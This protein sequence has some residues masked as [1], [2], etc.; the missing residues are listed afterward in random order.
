M[1]RQTP[2]MACGITTV[3][4]LLLC[5]IPGTVAVQTSAEPQSTAAPPPHGVIPVAEVATRATEMTTLLRTWNVQVVPSPAIDTIHKVLPEASGTIDLELAVTSTLL[6]GQPTLEVLQN[7][8]QLWQRRH[9]QTLGWLH[10]L[11]ERASQLQQVVQRLTDLHTTWIATRAAAQLAQAPEP[12]FQQI[13]ATLAA[14]AAA[15]TPLQ[16]QRTAA[17]DLQS[18]VAHE[19]ARCEQALAQ[20]AQVQ[21]QA[22]TGMLERTGGRELWGGAGPGDRAAGAGARAHP[23]VLADPPPQAF[24]TGYGD[25]AI[26]F[27]LF[28]WPDHFNHWGQVKSDLTAAV[29]EAVSAAGLSFPFPQREVRVLHDAAAGSPSAPLNAARKTARA[30]P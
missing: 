6:Q 15:Q 9:L 20:I 27:T 1:M 2:A 17:L 30:D 22:V 16:A 18:R 7:Q 8:Q 5:V 25:S 19:V 4:L 10:V 21:Q 23:Q 29:Y 13:D 28:A 26:N 11:T 3:L 24:F 12:L 14:L